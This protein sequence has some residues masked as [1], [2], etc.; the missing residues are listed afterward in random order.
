MEPAAILILRLLMI[1]TYLL[2]AF[3]AVLEGRIVRSYAA[4][5]LESNST[6]KRSSADELAE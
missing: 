3:M 4:K 5:A 1:S 6:I 2:T